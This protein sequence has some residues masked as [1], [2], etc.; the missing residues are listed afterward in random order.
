MKK[1][2]KILIVVLVC[3]A[4]S[5]PLCVVLAKRNVIKNH[6]HHNWKEGA[7]FEEAK[8]A[9]KDSRLPTPY[10]FYSCTKCKK[11]ETD[12]FRR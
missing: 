10:Y 3:L 4:L 12:Y 2:D 11:V 9:A 8:Q 1:V 5:M 6:C 7:P